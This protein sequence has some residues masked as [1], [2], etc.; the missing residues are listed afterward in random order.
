MTPTT[1]HSAKPAGTATKAKAA[2]PALNGTKPTTPRR[3][4]FGKAT[5]DDYKKTFFDA[6]PKLKDK[7]LV[8]HAVEQ[9][10]L[11]RYPR[12]VNKSEIHSL[13]NLRG[14][15]KAR[16]S[17]L[18]LSAIR[19][20]WNKFYRQVKNPTKQQL[21]DWATRIDQKYGSQFKPAR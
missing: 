6:H 11:R 21:L 9:Q 12:T 16:N 15:P 1:S 17:K 18:H 8:H 3:A 5:T 4:S 10:A 2:T 13:E 20:E 7:V 19:K 14:V